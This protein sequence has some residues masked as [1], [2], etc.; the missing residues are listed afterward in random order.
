MLGQLSPLTSVELGAA[1]IRGALDRAG[2]APESVDHVILG[3][4]LPAG[5]GQGPARQAAFAAGIPMS[6]PAMTVNKLCLSGLQAIILAD[7]YIRAGLATTVVA[8]GIE[9]MS[10]AP[11]LLLGS[12]TGTRFGPI[13]MA[14]HMSLDGLDDPFSGRVMGLLTE[15]EN[16]RRPIPRERMDEFAVLSHHRAAAA[17][18]SGVFADEIVPVEVAQRRGPVLVLDT[19]EGVRPDASVETLAKLPGAFR[20]G[21]AITA[22]NASPISDGAAALVLMDRAAA[23]AAGLDWIAELGAPGMVAG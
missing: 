3:H 20:D 6:T 9:S 17:Q 1:A 19:D 14:D 21:G 7:Q 10:R 16:D 22:G 4:V 18:A 13:T 23:E 8:G 2:V 15:D 5:V 11:H 12:R